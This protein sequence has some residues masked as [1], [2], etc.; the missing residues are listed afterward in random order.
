MIEFLFI[1]LDRFFWSK[2]DPI[3]L[4]E[5]LFA[6]GNIIS[7]S[8]I[9]YLLPA[10]EALGPLQIS[11]GRMLVVSLIKTIARTKIKLSCI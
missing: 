4:S 8:R 1:V 3:N 2:Y 10:N 7:F 11:L 5:G 9:S 6:I